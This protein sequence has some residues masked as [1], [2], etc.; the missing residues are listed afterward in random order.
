MCA[1]IRLESE[2]H[3]G[4]CWANPSRTA[5][6]SIKAL[7]P[8]KFPP[9][10]FTDIGNQSFVLAPVWPAGFRRIGVKGC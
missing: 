3:L 10:Y 9:L 8:L 2:R 4:H 6:L 1:E 7:L 5:H